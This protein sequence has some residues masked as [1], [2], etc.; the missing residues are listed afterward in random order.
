MLLGLASLIASA[1]A[2]LFGVHT[3]TWLIVQAVLVLAV[4]SWSWWWTIAHP[5]WR[6]DPDR[7]AIH[8]AGRSIVAFILT[9]I[10]PFF[11]IYAW[12]GYLDLGELKHPARRRL[13][14]FAVAVTLAGSQSGGF[15]IAG[16]L[17]GAI[18]LVL[19]AVNIGLVLLLDH[20]QAQIRR[21]TEEQVAMIEQ[22][23]RLNEDLESAARENAELH[24]TVVEQA[25][26]AGI[27]DERQRLAREI[28]DTIAQSLAG[29]LAQLQA[30]QSSGEPN[31]RVERA[32]ALVRSA[33][34]DARRSVLDLSPE[35]LSSTGLAEAVMTLVEEWRGDHSPQAR[36]IVTGNVRALHPEVEATVLRVAQEALANVG[37]HAD[38]DRV[39]VTL[40]YDTDQVVLDV[41]DDGSGFDPAGD[42][43]S[44]SFGLRG[45]RQRADRLNGILNLETCPGSGTAI[46]LHLPALPKEAA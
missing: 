9:W 41:R 32:T 16:V 5:H 8:F 38:A 42:V 2:S 15:P 40:T 22:L 19:L 18:F 43:G 28:H 3:P 44:T 37:K 35:P 31:A 34:G 10:N 25:R 29:A 23:G 7:M 24:K 1:T 6:R 11:G 39:G 4:G 14:M 46:S 30:V 21:R 12:V 36:V 45:M 26:E 27:L 17:Q 13:G 33:L 20:L